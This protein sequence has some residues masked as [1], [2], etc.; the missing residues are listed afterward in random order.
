MTFSKMQP[1]LAVLP[2][3]V[4]ISIKPTALFISD[5]YNFYAQLSAGFSS[6]SPKH[7]VYCATSIFL[8]AHFVLL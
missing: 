8:S 4:K 6:F 2:F 5:M 3:S 1:P 7:T